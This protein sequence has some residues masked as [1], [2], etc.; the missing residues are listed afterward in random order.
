MIRA[1]LFAMDPTDTQIEALRSHCGARRVAYNWALARVR[2]NWAQRAAEQT[3][4]V[5]G[6]ELTPWINT[7]A[8]SLRKEWNEANR[9][10]P[11]VA[12][13]LEGG[14]RVRVRGSVGRAR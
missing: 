3:Y 8:Y 12:G 10:W 11:V 4:G 6:D 5:T 7:A 13:E 9:A 1:Y 2:A 14:V